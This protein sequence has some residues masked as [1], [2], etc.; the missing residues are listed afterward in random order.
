MPQRHHRRKVERHDRGHNAQRL[1]HGIKVNAGACV[2]GVFA[3]QQMWRTDAI[4]DHFQ[5]ALQIA[6][7]IRDGLAVFAAQCFGQFV[8]VAV[9]QANHGHHHAGTFLWVGG[10]PGG[11]RFGG[12]LYHV[13]GFGRGCD[14]Q[15]SLHFASGGVED[16]RKTAR[17]AFGHGAVNKVSQFLHGI[18]P[19]HLCTG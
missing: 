15:F 13:I 16:V 14:G 12:T 5:A 4:F 2:I 7:G 18:L 1:T 10:A 11:L 17:C 8:H 19:K 6:L 9:H 3:L